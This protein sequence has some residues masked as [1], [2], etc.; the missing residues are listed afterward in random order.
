MN[1]NASRVPCLLPILVVLLI[2]VGG[3]VQRKCPGL[4]SCHSDQG[5]RPDRA[6]R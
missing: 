1:I 4:G 5:G 3:S 6:P 2:A